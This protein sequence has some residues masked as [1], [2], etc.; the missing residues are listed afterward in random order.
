MPALAAVTKNNAFYTALRSE[1]ETDP[2]VPQ[3]GYAQFR[4]A[5]ADGAIADLLNTIIVGNTINDGV[6]TKDEFYRVFVGTGDFAALSAQDQ[7][8]LGIYALQAIVDY[9]DPNVK[10]N[11]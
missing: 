11:L 8:L 1:I 3:L 4:T 6:I 5:G 9:S 2:S 10:A 7:T